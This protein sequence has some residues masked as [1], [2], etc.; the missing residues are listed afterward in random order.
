MGAAFGAAALSFAFGGLTTPASAAGCAL[1]NLVQCTYAFTNAG[2]LNVSVPFGSVTVTQYGENLTAGTVLH[3]AVNIAPNYSLTAGSA[4]SAFSFAVGDATGTIGDRGNI[5]A[6]SITNTDPS[7][8]L[9]IADNG[10]NLSDKNAPFQYFNYALDCS[11]N[12]G[13]GNC[14][15]SF[16]FDFRYTSP[17]K[18]IPS[19]QNSSIWFA[20]D[21]CVPQAGGTGCAATGAVGASMI[22]ASQFSA[23]PGPI[24]GAGLPGLLFA[25]GGLAM[26]WRRR[27]LAKSSC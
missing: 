15:Q 19:T 9:S 25:G 10:S 13:S 8:T 23:V 5:I 3:F 18:L 7:R 26:W 2:S 4:H 24:V 20:A 17:G 27:K 16:S 22:E 12:G 11:A 1:G 6:S 21:I 14:G